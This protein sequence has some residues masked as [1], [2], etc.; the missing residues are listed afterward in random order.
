M[1]DASD[2]GIGAVLQQLEHGVWKPL[3][4]FSRKLTD[5]QKRYSTYDGELLAAYSSFLKSDK[6]YQEIPE[7]G[8]HYSETWPLEDLKEEMIEGSKSVENNKGLFSDSAQD[9]TEVERILNLGED[10]RKLD[11]SF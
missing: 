3:S 10:E 8:K 7:L 11:D 1:V 4:F 9:H 2:N 5:A 6:E